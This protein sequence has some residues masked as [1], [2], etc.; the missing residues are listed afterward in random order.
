[1][2]PFCKTEAESHEHLFIY[3]IKTIEAWV[4][5]EN[6]LRHYTAN[7]C[8]YLNDANRILGYNLKL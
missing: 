5:V 2:C 8:F 4:Y 1:M 7:I 3:C 6:M